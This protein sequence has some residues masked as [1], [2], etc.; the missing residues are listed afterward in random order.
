MEKETTS[1]AREQSSPSRHIIKAAAEAIAP[2]ASTL[3]YCTLS[4][5][6]AEQPASLQY[7]SDRDK[8]KSMRPRMMVATK[9]GKK[10][11]SQRETNNTLTKRSNNAED[12]G[13][14]GTKKA[15]GTTKAP[16]KQQHSEATPDTQE[17]ECLS[18]RSGSRGLCGDPVVRARLVGVTPRFYHIPAIFQPIRLHDCSRHLLI[19]AQQLLRQ[20][21]PFLSYRRVV[22]QSAASMDIARSGHHVGRAENTHARASSSLYRVTP[23]GERG[24]LKFVLRSKLR[25]RRNKFASI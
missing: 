4:Q 17:S 25:E 6:E 2:A 9:G 24:W 22:S 5:H 14:A 23:S 7:D 8:E 12:M 13:A 11:P 20:L 1:M 3:L 21:V 19:F 15:A 16:P 10:D 18:G